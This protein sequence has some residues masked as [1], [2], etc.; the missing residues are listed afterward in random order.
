MYTHR[1]VYIYIYI[2]IGAPRLAPFEVFAH[3]NTSQTGTLGA[4]ERA[5]NKEMTT[6]NDQRDDH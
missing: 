6:R 3:L 4:E 1:Y 5:G 2:Y